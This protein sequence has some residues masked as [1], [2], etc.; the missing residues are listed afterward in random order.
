MVLEVRRKIYGVRKSHTDPHARVRIEPGA[1][2][3]VNQ[4]YNIFDV[5]D[6]DEE[7]VQQLMSLGH[8]AA[9]RGLQSLETAGAAAFPLPSPNMS[10]DDDVSGGGIAARQERVLPTLRIE[11]MASTN[12]LLWR[13][14]T[15]LRESVTSSTKVANS[16]TARGSLASKEL[17]ANLLAALQGESPRSI[18]VWEHDLEL[19]Q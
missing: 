3:T 10:D 7:K 13:Y 12:L 8:R 17:E 6:N 4:C 11:R 16:A 2:T 1:F 18:V 5:P 9:T 15:I 19:R 14:S